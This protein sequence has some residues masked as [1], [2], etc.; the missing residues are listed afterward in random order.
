M[1]KVGSGHI[2]EGHERLEIDV[3]YM[4]S[5]VK[6]LKEMPREVKAA[7]THFNGKPVKELTDD[8]RAEFHLSLQPQSTKDALARQKTRDPREDFDW[9]LRDMPDCLANPEATT[10]EEMVGERSLGIQEFIVCKGM[11]RAEKNTIGASTK[12]SVD[13]EKRERGINAFTYSQPA[14]ITKDD[15]K[16]ITNLT[17]IKSEPPAIEKPKK[18]SLWDKLFHKDKQELPDSDLKVRYTSRGAVF[19]KDKDADGN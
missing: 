18:K 8:E 19:Y 12:S 7:P 14:E 6:K 3:L 9:I 1:N 10:V 15:I 5:V 13:E 17:E 4:E 16:R 2:T 11:Q